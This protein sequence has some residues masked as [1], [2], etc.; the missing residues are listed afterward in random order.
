MAI[1]F[2]LFLVTGVVLLLSFWLAGFWITIGSV[3]ALCLY[4]FYE[5]RK[6]DP[7]AGIRIR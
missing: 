4:C 7:E 2:V 5:A 6:A 1:R 3:T